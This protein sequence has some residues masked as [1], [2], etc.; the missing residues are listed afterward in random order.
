MEHPDIQYLQKYGYTRSELR[1][2]KPIGNCLFCG[3]DIVR[4]GG[5]Y[6]KS[7][8]GL[9]CDMD[10]CHSYYEIDTRDDA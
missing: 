6:V 5:G 7:F 10:C 4:S 2:D 1:R 8:D 3:S 9:F